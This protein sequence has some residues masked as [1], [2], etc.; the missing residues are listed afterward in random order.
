MKQAKI[1]RLHVKAA[2]H[3]LKKAEAEIE[4][5]MIFREIKRDRRRA[6]EQVA[7]KLKRRSRLWRSSA[8]R[9]RRLRS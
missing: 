5:K 2:E 4:H 1:S 6:A 9:R 8:E 3:E 7:I